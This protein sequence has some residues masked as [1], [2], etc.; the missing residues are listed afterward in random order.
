MTPVGED[1]VE[2][3]I[4]PTNAALRIDDLYHVVIKSNGVGLFEKGIDLKPAV[5][6]RVVWPGDPPRH[7]VART[8]YGWSA[9]IAIPLSAF[10][11]AGNNA[12]WGLNVARNEPTR[13]EY[14]DWARAPRTCYDP[15]SL[16]NLLM[17]P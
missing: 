7:A 2:L 6:R 3:L 13:G 17:R 11:P 16:G 4:D 12:V 9:E 1:L 5:C 10:G 15:R 8:S 14:S